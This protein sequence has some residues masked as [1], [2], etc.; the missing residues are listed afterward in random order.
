MTVRGP[1]SFYSN[2]GVGEKNCFEIREAIW[3]EISRIL[4]QPSLS[5]VSSRMPLA[6]VGFGGYID[7]PAMATTSTRSISG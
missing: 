6:L 7:T 3:G 1:G 4:E 2:L 5:I